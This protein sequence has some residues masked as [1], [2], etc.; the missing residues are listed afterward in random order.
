MQPVNFA[1]MSSCG[2]MDMFMNVYQNLNFLIFLKLMKTGKA[3]LQ[4]NSLE[5]NNQV[6]LHFS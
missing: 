6:S 3:M 2:G 5:E 4:S 1:F